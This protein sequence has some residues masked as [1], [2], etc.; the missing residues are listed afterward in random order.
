MSYVMVHIYSI[1]WQIAAAISAIYH[2]SYIIYSYMYICYMYHG[3]IYTYAIITDIA[4]DE[5]AMFVVCGI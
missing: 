5:Y 3:D 4:A 2:V 1:F